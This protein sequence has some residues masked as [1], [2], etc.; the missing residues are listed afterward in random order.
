M[1][2]FNPENIKETFLF[3]LTTGVSLGCISVACRLI[4]RILSEIS[5]RF[6]KNKSDVGFPD[7]TYKD[8]RG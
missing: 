5:F 4:A 2:M 8:G 1:E 7:K 3:I 6:E